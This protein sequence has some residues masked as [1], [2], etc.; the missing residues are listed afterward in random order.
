MAG[1]GGRAGAPGAAQA[2]VAALRL[3]AAPRHGNLLV[4]PALRLDGP[5]R[6]RVAPAQRGLV[7]ELEQDLAVLVDGEHVGDEPVDHGRPGPAR[8]GGEHDGAVPLQG[9]GRVAERAL[10]AVA[11]RGLDERADERAGAEPALDP[12]R[13]P[14]LGKG[15]F[16]HVRGLRH[17]VLSKGLDVHDDPAPEARQRR[18]RR[19][20]TRYVHARIG[21]PRSPDRGRRDAIVGRAGAWYCVPM[22]TD[23]NGWAT[24]AIAPLPVAE[25]WTLLSPDPSSRVDAARWAHQA[26]TF[27]R[28][29]LAVVE[30]KRYPAGTL[31]LADRVEVEIAGRDDP[32]VTRVLVGHGAGGS[33]AGGP[34]GGRGGRAGDRR[35][36]LRRAPPAHAPRLAGAR[37][38]GTHAALAVAAVL[39]SLFLAPV[40]PPGGGTI[41]GVKG[42]RERL[43]ALGFRT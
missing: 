26:A 12:A 8:R 33:R 27:F 40:V 4:L 24:G 21:P 18:A 34:R 20:E 7:L 9:L 22:D 6:E 31:P 23:D 28:A 3:A 25:A 13:L 32:A 43:A 10:L 39:A 29:R 14:A 1:R 36:G 30:D 16:G 17:P 35:R 41:F 37:G 19:D 5:G 15:G 42:A 11:A 38:Q 2:A